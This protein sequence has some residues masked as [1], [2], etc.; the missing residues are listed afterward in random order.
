LSIKRRSPN[1]GYIYAL[2]PGHPNATGTGYVYEH[3]FVMEQHLDRF[4]ERGEVV[5]HK[6]G[7]KK[8]NRLT[9]LKLRSNSKHAAEHGAKRSADATVRLTCPNC[10][11]RFS[12]L[13]SRLKRGEEALCSRS[14]NMSFYRKNGRVS[15]RPPAK[16]GS[17]SMYGYHG[18][19][20]ERCKRGQRERARARRNKLASSKR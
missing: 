10:G 11:K 19:R 7:K 2:V 3:R 13:K 12:R 18:C 15:P 14:C 4:L 9:N 6:N 20:C 1:N 16:H 17:S 8:D 5:H